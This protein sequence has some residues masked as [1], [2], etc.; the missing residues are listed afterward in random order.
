MFPPS[1]ILGWNQILGWDC[2]LGWNRP[3]AKSIPLSKAHLSFCQEAAEEDWIG[4]MLQY[5]L[6][7]SAPSMLQYEW[8]AKDATVHNTCLT[9]LYTVYG[10]E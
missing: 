2:I 4:M 3:A 1:L 6:V 7:L 9:L 10:L 8:Y 5:V